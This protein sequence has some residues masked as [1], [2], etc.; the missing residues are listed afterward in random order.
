MRPTTGRWCDMAVTTY[1][2]Q[3]ARFWAEHD[4]PGWDDAWDDWCYDEAMA[5]PAQRAAARKAIADAQAA[6]EATERA[7]RSAAVK[8]HAA[9][10]ARKERE[11][12]HAAAWATCGV[13]GRYHACTFDHFKAETELQKAALTACERFPFISEDD[14]DIRAARNLW[15]LGPVG[16]GKT[17]LACAVLRAQH[18]AGESVVFTTPRDLVR[19]LRSHWGERGSAAKEQ[20]TLARYTDCYA[21]VIDDI[22]TSF[23]KEAELVQLFEVINERDA[24]DLHTIITS[25]L[26]PRALLDA[27]GER[28]YSRLRDQAL[29]LR[30]DGEDHRRP[31]G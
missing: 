24:H 27:L 31:I 5:D 14:G 25:N 16:R 11:R 8:A 18:Q 4:I 28:I 21:L 15:L 19:D 9:A 10:A 29:V 20:Q 1:N 2:D 7:A 3:A 26:T 22:G 17:H 23:G 13:P 12:Q 6:A 30:L